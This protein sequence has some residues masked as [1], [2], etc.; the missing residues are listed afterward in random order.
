MAKTPWAFAMAAEWDAA[1]FAPLT[2]AAELSVCGLSLQELANTAWAFA[3]AAEWDAALFA[4]LAKA[5][6]PN[7]CELNL[8]TQTF[9]IP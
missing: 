6:E 2:K 4:P 1:L 7:E 5:A 3:M 8:E 9:E